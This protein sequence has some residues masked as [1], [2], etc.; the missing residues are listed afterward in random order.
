MMAPRMPLLLALFALAAGACG[1]VSDDSGARIFPAQGVIRGTV[2]YRGPRPC[3]REGHIVGN[4]VLLVF[5]Q[6]NAPPPRGLANTAVNFADVTGDAL[7]GN[8][9]R[10]TGPDL[11]CPLQ[12][13]FTEAITA[14]APFQIAPLAGGSYEIRAFFDFTGNFLPEFTI[15][16]SP[17]QGDV[18]G[19]NI[20]TA[21]ALQPINV[22]NPN[23]QP[24]FLPIHVGVAQPPP[25]TVPATA[26]PEYVIPDRG[27]V[28]DNVTVTIGAPVP[29]PRPYFYAEGEQ[30]SF[31][32]NNPMSLAA[33]VTQSSDRP[34]AD[35][36]GID[37]A[38]ETD[39]NSKP[40]LTLPQ[41]ISVFAPPSGAATRANTNFFE[42]KFPHLRLQWGIPTAEL[43]TAR[44][45]PFSM[46]L[47]PF[48]QGP[49][50]AGFLV[51]QNAALDPTTQQ[52]Q[53]LQ[54]PEG[55]NVPELWPRV[56]LTRLASNGATGAPARLVVLQAITL[57]G[58]GAQVQPDSLVGT[59]AA[60]LGG[61]LFD[62]TGTRGP[63]PTI[64]AQDHLTVLLRPSALCFDALSVPTK[65]D[66]RGTL[67]TPHPTAMTADLDCSNSPC[68]AN[69][70]PDQP[71]APANLATSLAS[72]VNA[73]IA[74]C[75]PM[76]RYGISV[77]Y[78]DGQAWT[79]PNEAGVCSGTE[80]ATDYAGLTCTL[81]PRPV[82]YSQGARAVVEIVAPQDPAYCQANPVPR[83]CSESP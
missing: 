82:L 59:V 77:I 58:N 3:S 12:A 10:Y 38:A 15:R 76:G 11:Y 53:P 79:V 66:K 61:T 35:S 31:D 8:E 22:G 19:G 4:A 34:P 68:T 30:V 13:G 47:A 37:G 45:P 33:S 2:V 16:N 55:N 52:Y 14:S 27:F 75:L 64:F 1:S 23:Y 56:V 54:I 29:T 78:P 9:P 48:G 51:W 21:D 39:A 40:V 50:G 42:S 57:L 41:D 49:R 46:Q 32:L 25:P 44:T 60:A 74:A 24:R 83:A 80:G 63:R 7:F 43:G 81:K 36:T 65:P 28:A 73:T 62:T 6:R 18:A 71:I 69:G 72:L 5:N 26:V 67:V 20:D 70:A 17:E